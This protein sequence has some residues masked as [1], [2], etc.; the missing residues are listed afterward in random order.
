L[1]YAL[2]VLGSLGAISRES[3][4]AN[5]MWVT[6]LDAVVGL[7]VS[8]GYA[9]LLVRLITSG[10]TWRRI[11]GGLLLTWPVPFVPFFLAWNFSARG[12]A[13]MIPELVVSAIALTLTL[14]PFWLL[15][16]RRADRRVSAPCP[17]TAHRG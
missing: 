15:T 2:T 5:S 13:G 14:L 8:L 1:L 9:Y 10:I 11:V 12:L 7:A 3:Q 17:V 6:G 16:P 4:A